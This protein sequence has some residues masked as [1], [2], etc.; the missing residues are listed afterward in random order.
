MCKSSTGISLSINSQFILQAR[1]R[2]MWL[3]TGTYSGRTGLMAQSYEPFRQVFQQHKQLYSCHKHFSASQCSLASTF[4]PPKDAEV[5][6]VV[7]VVEY[8]GNRE[9]KDGRRWILSPP[10]AAFS[11][12]F[13]GLAPVKS[14]TQAKGDPFQGRSHTGRAFKFRFFFPLKA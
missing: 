4:L 3:D 1:L 14:L 2:Q 13:L 7:V 8:G 9:Q 5:R 10:A 11:P 6:R 12:L